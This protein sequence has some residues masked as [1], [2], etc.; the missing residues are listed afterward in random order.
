VGQTYGEVATLIG[1][2]ADENHEQLIKEVIGHT[3]YWGVDQGKPRELGN[4]FVEGEV[5]IHTLQTR[6]V[7][8][9]W[10]G[11]VSH[12]SIPMNVVSIHS[13]GLLEDSER[14]KLV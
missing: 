11:H 14:R 10:K 1:Q 8:R 3:V 4:E 12:Y 6:Q 5:R 2:I 7:R 13:F 9:S